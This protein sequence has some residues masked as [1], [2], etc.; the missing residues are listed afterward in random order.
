MTMHNP[1]YDDEPLDAFE[2]DIADPDID[3]WI[4][5]EGGLT[6]DALDFLAE[7]DENDR[8]V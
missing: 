8:F 2:L 3:V 6:A 7:E 4:D 5:E 1:Y